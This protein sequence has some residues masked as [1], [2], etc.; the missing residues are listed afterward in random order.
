MQQCTCTA[1]LPWEL[2]LVKWVSNF[3]QAQLNRDQDFVIPVLDSSRASVA[4][5]A[6]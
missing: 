2:V 5:S 3:T 6:G 1:K 4:R